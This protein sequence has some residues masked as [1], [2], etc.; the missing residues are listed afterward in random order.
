MKKNRVYVLA[1]ALALA[2]M[3]GIAACSGQSTTNESS[4][5]SEA[6][7]TKDA[8][9]DG[10]ANPWTEYATLDEAEEAAGF[11]L[12]V[13]ASVKGYD[14]AL[15]QV[16]KAEGTDENGNKTNDVILEYRFMNDT[17]QVS[18]RKSEGT[19]DISGVYGDYTVVD[20]EV[21]GHEVDVS[22]EG[23]LS[24]VANWMVDGYSYSVYASAGMDR[25]ALLDIVAEVA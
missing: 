8:S 22:C 13:P 5:G 4:S 24:Y 3:L 14:D 18:I 21:D 16:M 19:G 12:S 23:T 9:T 7:A 10:I 2:A 1:L 25:D 17:D 20:E 15:I 6:A 11:E